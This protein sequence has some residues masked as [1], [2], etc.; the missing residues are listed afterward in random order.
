MTPFIQRSDDPEIPPPYRF[1]GV[2]IH[3]F[4]LKAD[5]AALT[6][7]CDNLLNIGTLEERGFEYRPLLPFVALEVLHYPQMMS[8][9]APFSNWGYISQQ[10]AYA[11]FPVVKYD[12]F[13]PL[14]VPVGVSNFFPFLFVN[15]AWS[16]FSGRNVIGFPKM[17]GAIEPQIANDGA[18]SAAVSVPVFAEFSPQTQQ[19]VREV[20]R[21]ETEGLGGPSGDSNATWP[22]L[23]TAFGDLAEAESL[24][25]EVA[26]LIDPDL[27]S[28]VQLKQIR[29]AE[30]PQMAC[31]Q[32]LVHSEFHVA[33]V[34][35][36][37]FFN[38]ETVSISLSPS[39][40]LDLARQLGLSANNPI[41]PVLAYYTTCDMT[42]DNTTNLFINTGV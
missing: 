3:S 14:L 23:I 40:T 12:L 10:E 17:V 28:T 39:D 13:G 33:N 30:N 22:W 20:I 27:L 7:L 31:F 11:R 29:D 15:N 24:L 38:Q 16:A 37:Q 18:Y 35:L 5:I 32:G 36:P 25:L 34:S 19:A 9:T 4:E 26:E 1:P 8:G 41:H 21:L 6:T 2:S 42:F